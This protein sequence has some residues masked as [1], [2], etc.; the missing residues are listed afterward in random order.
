M[1]SELPSLCRAI[2]STEDNWAK[3]TAGGTGIVVFGALFKRVIDVQ[4]VS[5]V[6]KELLDCH[7][8]LRA[9]LVENAKGKMCF[10]ASES[11]LAAEYVQERS[12]PSVENV[13]HVGV[14][15][16]HEDH[17][18]QGS[19][20]LHK[21]VTEELNVTFENS[22]GK[23][24]PPLRLFN[25]LV[26][27]N[28]SSRQTVIILKLHSAALDRPSAYIIAQEFLSKLNLAVEGRLYHAS[29]KKSDDVLPAP[30]ED[31]IPKGKASKGILQ[32]GVDAVGYAVN[33]KKYALLPFQ[34]SFS[35]SGK[36]VFQSNI[37]CASL[38]KQGTSSLFAACE[39]QNVSWAAALSA[40]FLITSASVKELKDKKQD[41]FT[42]TC[43]MDCR[44]LLEPKLEDTVL[45][46]YCLGLPEGSKV[47]EGVEF[48]ELAKQIAASVDKNLS[49]AKQFSEMSV[50]G[51]LF[52]Q[53]MKRPTL[54]PSS[55]LRT[56]LFNIFI[57]PPMDAQWK[58]VKE[59]GLVGTLGPLSSM[60]F[61]G[62]C[63]CV[64]ETVLEGPELILS[65]VYPTPLHSRA[66]ILDTLQSSI[67][68]LLETC[69]HC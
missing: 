28:G 11:S 30:I 63:F 57:D 9:Q 68:L 36:T 24:L 2:G 19:L 33:S 26:Y 58:E 65:L 32:K 10:Q 69:S 53:V 3:S 17:D 29:S 67:S 44:A 56:A 1:A 16:P 60:H 59:L 20:A 46:N 18:K 8:I 34:P 54:T 15:I 22:D 51:M 41:E 4:H 49:K 66:Q 23:P 39:K 43:V 45:G 12:W 37:V 21:L 50:L 48:W 52:A 40:A 35:G 7:P 31:L 64:G 5:S 55:S 42:Y 61:V 6:V 62:P 14:F 13:D 47:K 25:V 38:G 27:P